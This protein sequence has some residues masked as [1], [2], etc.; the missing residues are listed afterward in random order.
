MAR[1][2]HEVMPQFRNGAAAGRATAREGR[3]AQWSMERVQNALQGAEAAKPK[4]GRHRT[5]N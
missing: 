1:K 2:K 4:R 5:G 3:K